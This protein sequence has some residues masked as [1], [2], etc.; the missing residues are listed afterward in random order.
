MENGMSKAKKARMLNK[1]KT[2]R[3]MMTGTST[4]PKMPD[5]TKPDYKPPYEEGKGKSYPR[6]E[7]YKRKMDSGIKTQTQIQSGTGASMPTSTQGYLRMMRKK[8]G[9]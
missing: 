8:K 4:R 1:N 7:Q 9:S 3:E 2:L 5:W 6:L